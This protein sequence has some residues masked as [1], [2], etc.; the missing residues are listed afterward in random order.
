M[1]NIRFTKFKN[2]E[3]AYLRD[4]EFLVQLGKYPQGLYFTEFR[5]IGNMDEAIEVYNSI[6]PISNHRK[7]IVMVGNIG[8]TIVDVER[9]KF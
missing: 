6:S 7:R 5:S 8:E 3:Y 4:T 2:K 9:F 1:T